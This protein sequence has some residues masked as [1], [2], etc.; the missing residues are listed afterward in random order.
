MMKATVC[1]FFG[2][3]MLLSIRGIPIALAQRALW[4]LLASR[5]LYSKQ[6]LLHH[7]HCSMGAKEDSTSVS[8]GWLWLAMWLCGYGYPRGTRFGDD[9]GA[10]NM[11]IDVL[12]C[13]NMFHRIYHS[14]IPL[15]SKSSSKIKTAKQRPWPPGSKTG[16]SKQGGYPNNKY[17]KVQWFQWWGWWQLSY[18]SDWQHR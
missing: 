10:C 12:I 11:A 7:A 9:F 2:C 5:P 1:F 6:L 4:S 8:Y 3:C 14:P 17:N 18:H 13:S 15:F 16:A